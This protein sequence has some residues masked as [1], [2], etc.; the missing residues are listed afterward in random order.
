MQ[1][2]L[3]LAALAQGA[4]QPPQSPDEPPRPLEA[5]A[6]CTASAGKEARTV[7]WLQGD[8]RI[9]GLSPKNRVPYSG[10]MKVVASTLTEVRLETRIGSSVRH[11]TARY[12]RC[13][14]DRVKQLYVTVVSPGTPRQLY[15]AVHN[16]Y[17]NLHRAT[18]SGQ[19]SDGDG[20]KGLE[21][22]FEIV[23]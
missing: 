12:V 11:A 5:R 7:E 1:T 23:P 4:G 17:D 16:D 19:A 15:C 10:T 9:V 8:Y 2:W 6:F 18:C 14:P 22:W 21:A 3:M 20:D 13:G